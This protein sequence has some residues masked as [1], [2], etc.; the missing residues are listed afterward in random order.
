MLNSNDQTYLW[1]PWVDFSPQLSIILAQIELDFFLVD[2]G[3]EI[4]NFSFFL[5]QPHF[6]I[7]FFLEASLVATRGHPVVDPHILGL[8]YGL[9]ER[10][11]VL[12]QML[13]VMVPILA[14][15]KLS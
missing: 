13:G 6:D 3:L 8:V 5:W 12:L 11:I 1:C 14:V 9:P 10:S 4:W 2:L 7:I 15:C